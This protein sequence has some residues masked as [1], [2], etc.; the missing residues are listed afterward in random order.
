MKS[1]SIPAIS[2]GTYG[3]EKEV[4]AEIIITSCVEWLHVNG[5]KSHLESIRLCDWN[6]ATSKVFKEK[7]VLLYRKKK[8]EKY[9][10][11]GVLDKRHITN[12]FLGLEG[13]EFDLEEHKKLVRK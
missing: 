4:C 10:R 3:F 6:E 7:L 8:Q 13:K 9:E 1:I 2:S 11:Y 12:P 5:T